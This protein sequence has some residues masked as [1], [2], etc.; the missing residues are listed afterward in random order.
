M[1]DQILK[2]QPDVIVTTGAV[3]MG[4]HDFVSSALKELG[5]ETVFHKVAIRPGKPIL[6]AK[7][8]SGP[9]VFG[10]PG[11]PVAT[12]VGWRFFIE[13][14]LRELMGLKAEAP[15]RAKLP[16]QPDSPEGLRCFY[17]ARLGENSNEV[18]VLSGQMSF[19][20]SPLLDANVWA[21]IPEQTIGKDLT[22]D[23]YPLQSHI[24][25][26]S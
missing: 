15:L 8:E 14:Y 20:V 25:S 9:V 1:I 24:G 7:F 10:L 19:M 21:V 23:V 12:V 17:K 22:I 3:S 11:N 26:Y 2:H 5:A 13:P 6:F 18:E 4:K 16:E